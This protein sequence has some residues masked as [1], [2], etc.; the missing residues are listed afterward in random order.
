MLQEQPKL[1]PPKSNLQ[2]TMDRLALVALIGFLVY[3]LIYWPDL[4][5]TVPV[6]F[7]GAGNPNSY[8]HKATLLL[9]P[10]ISL[11][12]F[13]L[14]TYINKKPYIFNYPVKITEENAERQYTLARNM[15]SGLNAAIIVGLFYLSWETLAL[16]RGESEGLGPWTIPLFLVITFLPI[17]VYLVQA[18]RK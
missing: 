1:V 17:V 9:L 10:L 15:I 11:V 6:H 14:L 5:E 16:I 4:P 12:Q 18:M 7:D 2:Y 3:F 13:F 8:G